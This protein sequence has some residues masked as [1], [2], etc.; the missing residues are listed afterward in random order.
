MA[1]FSDC[2]GGFF[3]R[4]SSFAFVSL[5]RPSEPWGLWDAYWEVAVRQGASIRMMVVIGSSQAHNIGH[6]PSCED[7]CATARLRPYSITPW[8]VA[9]N[10]GDF[11]FIMGTPDQELHHVLLHPEADMSYSRG[12]GKQVVDR[13]PLHGNG[14]RYPTA[15]PATS[16]GPDDSMN[17]LHLVKV[18]YDV[19]TTKQ[20]PPL[21]LKQRR[22]GC[23]HSRARIY[24]C[25]NYG[26][27]GHG[28][29]AQPCLC[30]GPCPYCE[31]LTKV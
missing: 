15:S 4:K 21:N 19:T 25:P 30:E 23:L 9:R 2:P 3:V 18:L 16:V 24:K 5:D 26:Q 7:A 8:L 13:W 17:I 20:Y 11:V 1:W 12:C 14:I 27:S 31:K 29:T 28:T 10:A 22:C 6:C